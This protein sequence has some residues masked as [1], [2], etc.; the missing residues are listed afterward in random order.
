MR[1]NDIHHLWD[2]I[3][4]ITSDPIIQQQ[5]WNILVKLI[6]NERNLQNQLP[7]QKEEV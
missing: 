1:Q 4:P 3:K 2:K 5:F 7:K 6:E